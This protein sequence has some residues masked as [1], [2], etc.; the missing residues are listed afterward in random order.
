MDDVLELISITP[1]KDVYGVER[2]IETPRQVFC[3]TR[4]ISRSEF[5][6]TG[7]KGLTPEMEFLIFAGDYNGEKLC[8]FH[9]NRYTIYRTYLVPGED[10]IEIYVERQGGSNG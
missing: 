5:Y 3:Q 10:Y 6:N 1:T 9:G 8:S 7:R 4:S 2:S